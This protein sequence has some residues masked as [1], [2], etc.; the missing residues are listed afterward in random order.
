MRI[1]RVFFALLRA[2]LFYPVMV[3]IFIWLYFTKAHWGYGLAVIVAILV[4]D[5]IWITMARSLLQGINS[6][7]RK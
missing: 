7:N 4:I 5:P 6:R 3:G 2:Y 1:V